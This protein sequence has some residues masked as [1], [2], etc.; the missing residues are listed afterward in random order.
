MLKNQKRYLKNYSYT[1]TMIVLL[2]L[3]TLMQF[4]KMKSQS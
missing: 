3:N 4:I 2:F 1:M